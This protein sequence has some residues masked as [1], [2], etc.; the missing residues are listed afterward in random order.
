MAPHWPVVA[1]VMLLLAGCSPAPLPAPTAGP[2]AV[3]SATP[4]PT[5]PSPSPIITPTPAAPMGLVYFVVDTTRGFR[6]VRESRREAADAR[7]AVEG[8]IAGPHD[9]DYLSSWPKDTRVLGI[10]QRAGVISVN[11]SGEARGANVGASGEAIMVQQLV[12]TVTGAVDPTAPV[13]ATIEGEPASW[14]HLSWDEPLTRQDALDVRL[15]VGIDSPGEAESVTSPVRLSG[16]ANVFEATLPWRVMRPDGT[17]IQEGFVT[18]TEG[19][20]FA[21]WE[22]TLTLPPGSYVF[23]VHDS[24]PSGGESTRPPDRDSRTFTVA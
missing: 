13:L 8:M 21:P 23:E 11:L 18:T 15:L 14:G 7:G 6:L 24:D 1:T 9:P 19:Q 20:A 16:E 5:S 3:S 17:V 4:S 2:T 22:L 12:W 10:E